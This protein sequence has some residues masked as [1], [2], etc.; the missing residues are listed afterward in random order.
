MVV[1]GDYCL[2]MI[3][4]DFCIPIEIS[5]RRKGGRFFG[6]Q[7]FGKSRIFWVYIDFISQ[8]GHHKTM[9]KLY[10]YVVLGC[11]CHYCNNLNM[12]QNVYRRSSAG[13]SRCG[14]GRS[15]LEKRNMQNTISVLQQQLLSSQAETQQVT[16]QLNCLITLVKRYSIQCTV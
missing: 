5:S 9:V 6:T 3:N 15:D 16:D 8:M 12:D 1:F 2:M 14:S 13:S 4:H 7:G 10:N 11:N